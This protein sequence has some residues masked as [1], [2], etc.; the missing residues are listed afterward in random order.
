VGP[1]TD[2]DVDDFCKSDGRDCR[3]L[4]ADP[5][6][7]GAV[8]ARPIRHRG[9]W[10]IR[11]KDASNERQSEVFDDYN[12]AVRALRARQVEADQIRAGTRPK[13]PEDRTFDEL[14]SLW[15]EKRIPQKRSAGNDRS[16][17]RQLKKHFGG[18]KLREIGVEDG[19]D[20]V[21]FRDDIEPKTIANH[22]TL[23]VT[24]MNYAAS[25]R[26]PWI[27]TV[28]S[29]K[30]PKVISLGKNFSYLRSQDE[31]ERF[32]RAARE[33]G[34]MIH[35]LFLTAI[36]TGMRA[37]ELAG[38]EWADISFDAANPIIMV[39]RSFDGP[40]KSGH[41]RPIP[42]LEVLLGDLRAWRLRHP[43]R[44]VFTNRDGRM[45]D[46]SARPFQEV[47]HRVLDRAGF[48]SETKRNGRVRRYITFHGL[49]HTFASTW[50][51]RG[52]SL[53]KLQRIL[54]HQSIVMTERY[55]HLAPNAFAEDHGRFGSGFATSRAEVIPIRAE[56]PVVAR[57]AKT[58][59][60]IAEDRKTKSG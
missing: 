18:R 33:E 15:E 37:G 9:K 7:K 34:E 38:L 25:L 44:L 23:L 55:A 54:G 60:P 42:I 29:F 17:I 12:D 27:L 47:L 4:E 58:S 24:M 39:Q 32:L 21:D 16:I 51:M 43:G 3:S 52:G 26:E 45:L 48:P 14:C 41:S 2:R 36:A 59:A 28:P 5:P 53:F 8:M 10:R 40:T 30:K 1:Q 31:I 19:D 6:T 20:Y 56:D 11:W 22:L 13:K 46:R 35:M 49:R 50:M 57:P